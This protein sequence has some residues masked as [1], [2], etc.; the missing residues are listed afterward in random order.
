MNNPRQTAIAILCKRS[1][2][3]L[4]VDQIR[5]QELL[6]T[7][8]DNSR[9]IHLVTALIYGVLR[10]QRYLDFIIS[11]FSKHPL[12]KMK[13]LTKQALRLG[14]FQICFMD[15]I[16][17]SAAVNET[18]KALQKAKQPK[19]LTGFVNGLLRSI[20]RGHDKNNPCF[21]PETLPPQ[22]RF[23]HPDWLYGRW[24]KKYGLAETDRICRANN[25]QAPLTLRIRKIANRQYFLSELKEL[26][27]DAQPGITDEAVILPDYKGNI[28][29]L[30][31]YDAGHFF[32]QD[33]GAQLISLMLLP[34]A[35]GKHLDACAG[36][37]GKTM[38]IADMLCPGTGSS[39]IAVEP[40]LMRYNL[41]QENISRAGSA[42]I[43]TT[44][45]TSL[46]DFSNETAATFQSV[47][48]DAPC[49]G[50]GVIRNHPD[51]RW[52]R[53]PEDLKR[54]QKQ[55]IDLL[56]EAA[57]LVAPAGV[58]VYATCST[59]EEENEEV[60]KHFLEQNRNFSVNQ[61]KEI[62]D[63]AKKFINQ[64][65]FLQMLPDDNHG[66]FFACRMQ[67]TF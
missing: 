59:E 1:E 38:H 10:N 27:I 5:D 23:S 42:D 8:F 26:K 16:P 67:K 12:N 52:N 14:V 63:K 39:V 66:G 30:P 57:P 33:E 7:D 44:H 46:A 58:L 11:K 61:P 53:Q 9:D 31:G 18:V 3:G 64:E 43:T 54:Y 37:G 19:W 49:S 47:L 34:L 6:K 65:G 4:P 22:I 29:Q 20:A 60:I 56:N 62:P 41:L 50:I 21:S 48:I 2:T 17:D 24:L 15:R 45:N 55:Q 36:L 51:I 40:N 25:L 32:V 35:T 28:S 13:T